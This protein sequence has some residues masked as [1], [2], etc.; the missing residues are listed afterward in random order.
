M[1]RSSHLKTACTYITL[2]TVAEKERTKERNKE[3]DNNIEATVAEAGNTFTKCQHDFY[4]AYVRTR[5]LHIP[6]YNLIFSPKLLSH[7]INFPCQFSFVF[8]RLQF[9]L[10]FLPLNNV[11]TPSTTHFIAL[12]LLLSSTSSS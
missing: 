3:Q 7:F 5:V 10:D 12:I 2:Q 4:G 6:H 1:L 11:Y 8:C 9:L